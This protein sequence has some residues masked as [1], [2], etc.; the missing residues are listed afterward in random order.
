MI[1]IGS[2]AIKAHISSFR[3]PKDIDIVVQS[4]VLTKWAEQNR[5]HIKHLRQGELSQY[6]FCS[7]KDGTKIQFEVPT[8]TNN[9]AILIMESEITSSLADLHH[10]LPPLKLPTLQV[11]GAIKKSHLIFPISWEKHITD[12]HAIKKVIGQVGHSDLVKM[13]RDEIKARSNARKPKL[14]MSNKDFFDGS[15]DLVKRVVEH[16]DIHKATCYGLAPIFEQMKTDRE[17]A[18][19]DRDLFDAM[20]HQNQINAVREEAYVIAIERK[21]LPAYLE[22]KQ[23]DDRAAYCGL[24]SV[25]VRL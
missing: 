9:S 6:Y 21:L 12:Y 10:L 16:D 23:S 8:A 22:G 14:N 4:A 2:V 15:Q 1:L 19:C 20:P 24:S 18:M 13:R 7:L 17:K 3:A 5:E 25:S 11:L